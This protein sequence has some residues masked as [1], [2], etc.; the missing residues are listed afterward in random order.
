MN[1]FDIIQRIG[2]QYHIGNTETG[3]FSYVKALASV[4]KD[5][6]NY[7]KGDNQQNH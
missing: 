2:S 1:R 5:I 4:D 3:E 6:K 7:Q